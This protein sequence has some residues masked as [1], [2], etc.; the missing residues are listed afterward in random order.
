MSSCIEDVIINEMSWDVTLK[1]KNNF[2]RYHHKLY[3]FS[4]VGNNSALFTVKVTE[5]EDK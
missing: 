1:K 3:F 5:K 2:N 4:N